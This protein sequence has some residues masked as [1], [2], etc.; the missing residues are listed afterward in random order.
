MTPKLDT[1]TSHL[2][3]IFSFS[4]F[5]RKLKNQPWLLNSQYMLT[6]LELKICQES[7]YVHLY[8]SALRHISLRLKEIKEV[9]KCGSHY[10][11]RHLKRGMMRDLRTFDA[12]PRR[13]RTQFSDY[14]RAAS[15]SLSPL[16]VCAKRTHARN[17]E[18]Q[19]CARRLVIQAATLETTMA[20]TVVDSPVILHSSPFSRRSSLSPIHTTE[21]EVHWS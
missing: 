6:K 1:I 9:T 10:L 14:R 15:G 8:F 17:S 18:V 7:W 5:W 19:L 12:R 11:K 16:N 21:R 2:S 20:V 13:S 3:A 4:I